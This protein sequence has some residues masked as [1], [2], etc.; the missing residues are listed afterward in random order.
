MILRRFGIILSPHILVKFANFYTEMYIKGGVG[1][2]ILTV[3]N[4]MGIYQ[5]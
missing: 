4:L 2:R 5:Y 3:K 1:Y